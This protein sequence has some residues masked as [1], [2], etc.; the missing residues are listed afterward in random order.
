MQVSV[1]CAIHRAMNAGSHVVEE[2]PPLD[3]VKIQ[4]TGFLNNFIYLVLL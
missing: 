4:L 2:P 3:T 1:C